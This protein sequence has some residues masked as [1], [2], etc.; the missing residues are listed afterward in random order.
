MADAHCNVTCACP[1]FNSDTEALSQLLIHPKAE[2]HALQRAI[3]LE[4]DTPSLSPQP[5]FP[6]EPGK[7][8]FKLGS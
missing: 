8:A 4:G 5:D 3:D 1:P 2:V 7:E 6:E